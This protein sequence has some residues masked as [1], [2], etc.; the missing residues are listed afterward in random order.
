MENF[1]SKID[2]KLD[3]FPLPSKSDKLYTEY[4]K[5]YN[6]I[7]N[8]SQLLIEP[9]ELGEITAESLSIS[10]KAGRVY[11][12]VGQS[13]TYGDWVVNKRIV[14]YDGLLWKNSPVAGALVVAYQHGN[15]D[16]N[17]ELWA[18]QYPL[19]VTSNNVVAA[20][21]LA[22]VTTTGIVYVNQLLESGQYYALLHQT[23]VRTQDVNLTDFERSIAV[24]GMALSEHHLL[25]RKFS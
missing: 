16:A 22:E 9:T 25:F 19:F 18:N 7:K 11:M 10:A 12:R 6:A 3:N 8:A 13:V 17:S 15:F 20:G 23:L 14:D 5:I 4:I 1:S 24:I 2:F 21:D